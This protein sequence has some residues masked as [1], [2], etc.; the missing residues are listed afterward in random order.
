MCGWPERSSQSHHQLPSALV[1]VLLDRKEPL[2]TPVTKPKLDSALY[3]VSSFRDPVAVAR[4][5]SAWGAA[6]CLHVP[7]SSWSFCG[8]AGWAPVVEM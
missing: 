5:L 4:A 7:P 1:S 3:K 6:E 2:P 8:E